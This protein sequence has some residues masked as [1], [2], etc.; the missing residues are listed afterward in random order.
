M[1]LRSLVLLRTL[2]GS[3]P[4]C[5]RDAVPHPRNWLLSEDAPAHAYSIRVASNVASPAHSL[6]QNVTNTSAL[7]T[8]ITYSLVLLRTLVDTLP[9]NYGFLT[10]LYRVVLQLTSLAPSPP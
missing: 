8:S 1:S 2:V 3:L 6:M 4:L 7:R 5:S 10:A 9:L